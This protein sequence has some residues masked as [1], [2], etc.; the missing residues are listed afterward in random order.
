MIYSTL[1]SKLPHISLKKTQILKK[2]QSILRNFKKF[3][4]NTPTYFKN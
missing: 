1:V 4:T 3:D 2:E